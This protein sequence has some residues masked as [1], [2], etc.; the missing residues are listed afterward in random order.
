MPTL[1]DKRVATYKKGSAVKKKLEAYIGAKNL[2]FKDVDVSWLKQYA[3]YL[4]VNQ[5]NSINTVCSMTTTTNLINFCNVSNG[6]FVCQ[7]FMLTGV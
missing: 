5:K 1:Y 7:C 4:K 3:H 2:D 6:L